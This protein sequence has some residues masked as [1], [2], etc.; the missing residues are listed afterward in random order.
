MSDPSTWPSAKFKHHDAWPRL[1]ETL[2]HRE[3][4][5]CHACGTMP[6]EAPP[7]RNGRK[8][9]LDLQLWQEHDQWDRPEMRY[10]LLCGPCA[11][12]IIEPH[13]RLYKQL[14]LFAPAPGVMGVCRDCRWRAGPR[15][16][17]PKARA[18]G[19]AGMATL[20]PRPTDV[21]VCR[22]PR[23][24]SGWIKLYPGP[25]T[26]CDGKEVADGL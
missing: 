1:S 18:N 2:P 8:R 3:P 24:L 9:P 11:K 5:R 25:V 13:P 7:A 10:V 22:S 16:L 17:C 19:G 23:R 15:C 12:R 21:H 4:G 20:G 26:D 6:N 14:D